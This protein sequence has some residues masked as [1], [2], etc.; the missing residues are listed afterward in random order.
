MNQIAPNIFVETKYDGVNVGAIHT[1]DGVIA[2]DAPSYTRQARDWALQL[3]AVHH[4]SIQNLVLTDY[5]G[6]RI[7]NSRWFNAPL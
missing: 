4:K 7:L 1:N 5:N 6:D 3:G 2:I